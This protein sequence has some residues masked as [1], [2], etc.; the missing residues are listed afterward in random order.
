M[1]RR[2]RF[3]GA[4][5]G[6][7]A[8]ALLTCGL[9]SSRLVRLVILSTLGAVH[10][11]VVAQTLR[12][13][14]V[15]EVIRPVGRNVPPRPRAERWARLRESPL[16]AVRDK[17]EQ[18]VRQARMEHLE[19][20][21]VAKLFAGQLPPID[22]TEW[23]VAELLSPR[24]IEHLRAL[25]PD[26]LLVSG[27]PILKPPL[28]SIP[29][30]GTV[31]LHYGIAPAYRGEDTL[32]WA[33]MNGDWDNLG[34]TLHFIDPGVDTGRIISH[35]F[36]ARRGG[37]TES[38]LWVAAARTGATMVERFL[39]GCIQ[40]IIPPGMAQAASGRQYFR[41]ERTSL[42]DARY[43]L[44]RAAGLTPPPAEERIVVY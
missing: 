26:L 22:A 36:P 14:R 19:S 13:F 2:A 31:N 5:A 12:S 6:N 9:L 8:R 39:R 20:R 10:R 25:E 15:E 23:P 16:A 3:V 27:A 44:R 34:V 41:R 11:Y 29:R 35:G 38:D 30:Y 37:D 7:A 43:L 21:I 32:F 1:G 28:F 42:A 18:R 40:G 17:I 4:R 24:S 33:W